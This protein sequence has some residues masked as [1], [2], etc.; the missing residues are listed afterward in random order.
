M[1]INGS[2][3]PWHYIYLSCNW[4]IFCQY[5]LAHLAKGN[6]SFYHHFASDRLSSINFNTVCVRSRLCKLHK[7][8]AH[9]SQ[10]QVIMFTSCFPIVCGSLRLLPAGLFLKVVLNTNKNVH[11]IIHYNWHC[12]KCPNEVLSSLFAATASDEVYQLLSH[13]LWFSPSSS[14]TKTGHHDTCITVAEILLKVALNII[15]L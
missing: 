8:G 4:V 1:F 14:T 2:K 12:L 3:H 10:P 11:H 9:Y 6:V 5:F 13:C 7:K 15:N